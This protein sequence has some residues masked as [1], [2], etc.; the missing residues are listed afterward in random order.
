MMASSFVPGTRWFNCQ[1]SMRAAA[2]GAACL[3]ATAGCGD[4]APGSDGT[5][6]LNAGSGDALS[7]ASDCTR[8]EYGDCTVATCP[9][10]PEPPPQEPPFVERL[11]AGTIQI[12]PD[13]DDF[14]GTGTPEGE[15]NQYT[16]TTTG[17][18]LGEE[19]MTITA[20]G[21]P[22]SAFQGTI[23]VPLA[24]L[25]TSPVVTGE[26]GSPHEILVPRAVDF[27]FSWDAR[28]TGQTL[29]TSSSGTGTST[30]SCQFDAARGTGI[31]PAAALQQLAAGAE[32]HLILTQRET[33]STP[34]GDIDVLA[35]LELDSLDRTVYPYFVLE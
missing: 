8:A 35:G 1:A 13:R 11:H 3:V 19:I 5:G 33:I 22:I 32:I 18:L 28:G 6:G 30:I 10:S 16:F 21:G 9:P 4:P 12:V 23:Q 26:D 20:L 24:P 14:T 15:T 25:L 2:L 34:E 7:G 31:F 17:T 27:A 29:T